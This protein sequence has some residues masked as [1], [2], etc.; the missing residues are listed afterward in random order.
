MSFNPFNIEFPAI[1]SGSKFLFTTDSGI[2]YE[3]RFA[4][5]K[6]NMLHITIA[7]GVLNEEFEGE[8]YAMTNRGEAFRVMHSLVEICKYYKGQHPNVNTY[9][10][11][12][13]PTA[14]E[15]ADFPTKR[16]RLY[17]RYLPTIF[18][19]SWKIE[20]LGNKVVISKK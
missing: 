10:F 11:V 18:N 6:I 5:K 17:Q 3:V 13:E 19:E 7:F 14:D 9:E 4:R 12:G 16:L 20:V 2:N 1:A 15:D 8:E